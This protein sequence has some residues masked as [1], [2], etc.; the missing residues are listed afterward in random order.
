[1]LKIFVPPYSYQNKRVFEIFTHTKS[2]EIEIASLALGEFSLSLTIEDSDWVIIPVFITELL[3]KEGRSLIKQSANLAK[4]HSK[5]FALFSNSDFIVDVEVE[6]AYILTPGAYKTKPNQI[7]LPATLAEDPYLKWIGPT[8]EATPIQDIPNVGFCGQATSHPLKALKDFFTFAGTAVRNKL[9]LTL[10]NPGPIFLP[11]FQR[12]RLLNYFEKDSRIQTDF[13]L[14]NQYKGGAVSPEEKEKVE[15]E[16]YQNINRNLFTVCLRGMG[17][18]SVRFYQTL[19]MGRIPILVDTDER[20]AFQEF[21][22]LNT[23]IPIIPF[24]KKEDIVEELVTYFKSKSE[25]ELLKI[26]A[27]CREIWEEYYQK[28]GLIHYVAK[29]LSQVIKS[30]SH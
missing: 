15:K 18:Y 22:Q 12:K 26:Q 25:E 5:P 19:A 16:F 4:K 3:D 8:W 9:G 20:I 2:K 27:T 21:N 11:A 17:N 13:I 28:R 10:S 1:M 23:L 30:E 7:A 29:T 24:E 14:R 6:N